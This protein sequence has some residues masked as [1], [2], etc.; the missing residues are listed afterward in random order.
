MSFIRPEAWQRLTRRLP[1]VLLPCVGGLLIYQLSQIGW[2]EIAKS[3][4]SSPWFYLLFAL[5]Y[6]VLPTSE[7]LLYRRVWKFSFR[8]GLRVFFLKRVYNQDVVDYSGDVSLLMW[9]RGRFGWSDGDLARVIK[10]HSIIS[11]L[12]GHVIALAIPLLCFFGSDP[13]VLET[14]REFQPW[15]LVCGLAFAPLLVIC[16][17]WTRRA[18]F[19]LPDRELAVAL[20]IHLARIAVANAV[21]LLQWRVALPDQSWHVRFALLTM[22]CL[23]GRLPTFLGRDF[24]IVSAGVA[25]SQSLGVQAGAAAGVLLVNGVLDKAVNVAVFF[26]GMLGRRSDKKAAEAANAV[27]AQSA[28]QR[29][30]A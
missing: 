14:W 3:I 17:L 12:A 27:E 13:I 9:A 2:S 26:T 21:I 30:A 28:P 20:G 10:D 11:A 8:D 16:A 23:V 1:I 15:A 7:V 22:Q 5:G 29:S 19:F 18:I 4:P 6:A 25:A 24:L